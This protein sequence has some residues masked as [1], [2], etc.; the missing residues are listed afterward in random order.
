MSFPRVC[1]QLRARSSSFPR[2]R[3]GGRCR[4][5]AF[6]FT[7]I[8]HAVGGV[9]A[10]SVFLFCNS[11]C[12]PV[13]IDSCDSR[14]LRFGDSADELPDSRGEVGELKVMSAMPSNSGTRG[15]WR[16]GADTNGTC[17]LARATRCLHDGL[18][19]TWTAL[20]S[21]GPWWGRGWLKIETPP[22]NTPFIPL[23]L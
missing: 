1:S 21:F 23:Q 20:D 11:P 16:A 22:V 6:R 12:N 4:R 15:T 17:A 5:F 10:F 13:I 19:D 2:P 3:G 18:H 9:C 8:P 14:K 7:V